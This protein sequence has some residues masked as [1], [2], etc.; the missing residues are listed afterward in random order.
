[1]GAHL[2][3]QRAKR[4]LP[5]ALAL[6]CLA[7]LLSARGRGDSGGVAAEEPLAVTALSAPVKSTISP[8]VG[9]SGSLAQIFVVVEVP[10]LEQVLSLRY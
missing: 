6:E 3:K 4:Q 1:M 7:W 2:C 8:T 9:C 10:V 5:S